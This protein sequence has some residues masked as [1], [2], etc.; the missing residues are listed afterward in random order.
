MDILCTIFYV[1]SMYRYR[2]I[3][4]EEASTISGFEYATMLPD[5][6]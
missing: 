3:D 4:V 6:I 2:D 5:P 1:R